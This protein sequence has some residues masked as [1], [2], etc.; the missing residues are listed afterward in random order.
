MKDYLK[1]EMGKMAELQDCSRE[2]QELQHK[3]HILKEGLEGVNKNISEYQNVI[4]RV[5]TAIAKLRKNVDDAIQ[6]DVEL[7]EEKYVAPFVVCF[8]AQCGQE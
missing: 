8:M 2:K 7:Q 4:G 6:R 5:N 1:N 3:V